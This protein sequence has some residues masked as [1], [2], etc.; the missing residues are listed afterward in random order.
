MLV[1]K[2]RSE[3]IAALKAG[4]KEKKETL[5]MLVSALDLKAKDK[6]S[7][8]TVEEEIAV[9]QRELKQTKE[10]L[11]SS[12]KDRLDIVEKCTNRIN[13]I[14]TFLPT[15]MGE[16]ELKGIISD[17]IVKLGLTSVNK[18]DKGKIM[19]E[20][21]PLVKGKADGKVVNVIVEAFFE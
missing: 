13:V 10:T 11:D 6:R 7:A 18:S 15:Q 14:E 5:S 2:V 1:D 17:V 3:M 16:D 9:V 19:K 20:L 8:L 21:M 4:E 12:P